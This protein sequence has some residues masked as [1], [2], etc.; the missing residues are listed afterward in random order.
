MTK[1]TDDGCFLNMIDY[2]EV[3]ASSCKQRRLFLFIFCR[4]C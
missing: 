1:D 2:K 3:T 4:Y